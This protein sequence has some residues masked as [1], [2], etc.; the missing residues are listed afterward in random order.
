MNFEYKLF[1]IYYKIPQRYSMDEKICLDP[2]KCR[3]KLGYCE[4]LIRF[5]IS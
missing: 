4:T 5:L 1:Q 2:I 3:K